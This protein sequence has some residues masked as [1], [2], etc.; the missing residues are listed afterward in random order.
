MYV[1]GK[2]GSQRKREAQRIINGICK[3]QK[4]LIFVQL[5]NGINLSVYNV[6]ARKNDVMYRLHVTKD[7]KFGYVPMS[8]KLMLVPSISYYH[9]F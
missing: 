3:I 7:N 4:V 9:K 5:V 2:V 1:F 8:F 6:L